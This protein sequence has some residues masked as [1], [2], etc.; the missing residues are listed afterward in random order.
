VRVAKKGTYTVKASA[1][2]V[3]GAKP[4]TAE[5]KFVVK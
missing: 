1:D 4:V 3:P 5:A 2:L